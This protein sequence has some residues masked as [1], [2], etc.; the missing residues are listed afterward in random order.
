MGDL[1]SVVLLAFSPLLSPLFGFVFVA[2]KNRYWR[3]G[4]QVVIFLLCGAFLLS[5]YDDRKSL[6]VKNMRIMQITKMGKDIT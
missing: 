3:M 5:G 1:C 2:I 6:P 4:T